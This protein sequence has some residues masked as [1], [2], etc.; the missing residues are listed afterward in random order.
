M[1]Q[2]YVTVALCISRDRDLR[3]HGMR[4]LATGT[5]CALADARTTRIVTLSSS[6]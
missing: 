3:G 5:K 6:L 4:S 2:N 1:E